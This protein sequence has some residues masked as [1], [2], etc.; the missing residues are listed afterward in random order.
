MRHHRQTT[1]SLGMILVTLATATVAQ[2]VEYSPR[3]SNTASRSDYSVSY[4]S[5]PKYP[6]NYD[7]YYNNSSYNFQLPPVIVVTPVP[8]PEKPRVIGYV[9][10]YTD[11]QYSQLVIDA[12]TKSGSLT[13]EAPATPVP[14]A[15]TPTPTE[16]ERTAG[17]IGMGAKSVTVAATPAPTPVVTA[18]VM[19]TPTADRP[20]ELYTAWVDTITS[21]GII[22]TNVTDLRLR[23]V[24]LPNPDSDNPNERA[25]G[26][27]V[28]AGMRRVLNG[29][30]IYYTTGKPE[31]D[32][33][34][35][36]LAVAHWRDGTNINSLLI[37]S[38]YAVIVPEQFQS[39][40]GLQMMRKAQM[41]AKEAKRGFWEDVK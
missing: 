40:A 8:T 30:R 12:M 13:E 15:P 25:W 39:E 16:S 2:K 19:A 29:H 11:E 26:E 4:G 28:L 41:E 20:Q 22:K 33:K 27:K 10:P 14:A 32:D 31:K 35:T 5:R 17:L 9:K 6:S 23:A 34:G 7:Y 18:T 1:L 24:R 36:L 38:G 21:D 3:G 37:N